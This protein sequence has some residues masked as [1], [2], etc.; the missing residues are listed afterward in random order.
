MHKVWNI[1]PNRI[2][3]SFRVLHGM[4]M[5]VTSSFLVNEEVISFNFIFHSKCA[6]CFLKTM[7]FCCK[8]IYFPYECLC[9][10]EVVYLRSKKSSHLLVIVEMT[11]FVVN[12]NLVLIILIVSPFFSKTILV[13]FLKNMFIKRNKG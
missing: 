4:N 10:F 3:V 11:S 13:L 12:V 1:C 9:L 8:W 5:D 7:I 2:T 6:Y